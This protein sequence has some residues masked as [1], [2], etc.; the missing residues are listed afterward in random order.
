MHDGMQ[1]KFGSIIHHVGDYRVHLMAYKSQDYQ[2]QMEAISGVLVPN[3]LK[4]EG[5]LSL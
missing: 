2:A 1:D 5:L 4:T 3:Y